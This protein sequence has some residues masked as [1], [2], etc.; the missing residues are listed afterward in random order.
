MSII[1]MFGMKWN[2]QETIVSN[3]FD[4]QLFKKFVINFG[5]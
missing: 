2:S 5:V 1:S 3:L 4:I